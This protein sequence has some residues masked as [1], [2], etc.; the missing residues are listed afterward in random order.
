LWLQVAVL[1]EWGLRL[2]A[3]A[4]AVLAACKLAPLLLLLEQHTP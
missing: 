4:V 2:L 3:E 1:E